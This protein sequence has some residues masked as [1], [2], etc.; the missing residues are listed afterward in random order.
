LILSFF[1]RLFSGLNYLLNFE[2]VIQGRCTKIQ[3][4]L[5]TGILGHGIHPN[6]LLEFASSGQVENSHNRFSPDEAAI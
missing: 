4:I 2:G 1:L 6:H 5:I 3:D